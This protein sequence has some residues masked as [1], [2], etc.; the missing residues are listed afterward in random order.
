MRIVTLL[1]SATEVVAALGLG[2][3]LVGVSHECDYPPEVVAK[4][5][6][7]TRS[8]LPP[9]L[10]AAEIDQV[11]RER[12][13][14]GESLYTLD[15]ELLDALKPDLIITQELCEV[16]AVA[17]PLVRAA[18]CHL[19]RVPQIVSLEPTTV[20]GIFET[21]R[22]VATV[23]GVSPRAERV[24]ADL[25]ARLANIAG[26]VRAARTRPRALA[27]EWLLPPFSAGHWVPEMIAYAGGREMLA[28]A[29]Q[30]SRRV[31]WTSVLR[32]QPEYLFLMP[33]GYNI[34]MIER[35]LAQTVF[36]SEWW[37]LPAVRQGKLYALNA[38]SFF[39]RPSPR[40]VEGIEILAG[41][42]HPD[43]FP[44]PSD[45]DARCLVSTQLVL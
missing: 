20:E 17:A 6:V 3:H 41:I 19:A 22:T 45:T 13:H 18:V 1:P 16:C 43:L 27:L 2:D 25:R 37:D 29:G 42:L 21:L 15:Y 11:V 44:P 7:V 4:K 10:S 23:A 12:I 35:E 34:A 26:R 14:R 32:A 8:A 28:R 40:V 24:I 30:K 39:S 36:P 33:C 9:G 31:D 5:A 38:N